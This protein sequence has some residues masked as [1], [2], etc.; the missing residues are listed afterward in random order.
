MV[1]EDFNLRTGPARYQIEQVLGF[2][3][4]DGVVSDTYRNYRAY[5]GDD[6]LE[7]H[8]NRWGDEDHERSVLDLDYDIP[9][10]TKIAKSVGIPSD[11]T[12]TPQTKGR[13]NV[14]ISRLEY[15]EYPGHQEFE[16]DLNQLR[17]RLELIDEYLEG[18]EEYGDEL[19]N[20]LSR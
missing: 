5:I 9:N 15:D 4:T 11:N 14:T 19:T 20:K 6:N 12:G 10:I 7:I 8:I 3:G 18:V 16:H 1:D 17:E 2:K 13:E